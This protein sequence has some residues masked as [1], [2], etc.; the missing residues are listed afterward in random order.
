MNVM[1]PSSFPLNQGSL[2][3]KKNMDGAKPE[4]MVFIPAE[5]GVIADDG[6]L[7]AASLCVF[8]PAESGVIADTWTRTRRYQFVFIPAESGVIADIRIQTNKRQPV[9]SSFP[10]N[11]GSLRTEHPVTSHTEFVVL[12]AGVSTSD[13]SGMHV[14]II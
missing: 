9:L 3:T 2:R 12:L 10:L 13:Q 6:L 5:S 7:L 8:I 1:V 14:Q 4:A 11:Q